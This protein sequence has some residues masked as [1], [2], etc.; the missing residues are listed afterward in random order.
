MTTKVPPGFG[1][2]LLER[3][4]DWAIWWLSVADYEA[5]GWLHS[6]ADIAL[7]KKDPNIN[8]AAKLRYDD[9]PW[10]DYVKDRYEEGHGRVGRGTLLIPPGC[11]ITV[12]KP[13]E[14]SPL[15]MATAKCFGIPVRASDAWKLAGWPGFLTW[16]DLLPWE[17]GAAPP[18]QAPA[19]SA[20]AEGPSGTGSGTGWTPET[21]ED[22]LNAAIVDA[23]SARIISRHVEKDLVEKLIEGAANIL[24]S[25]PNDGHCVIDATF[26]DVHAR[27]YGPLATEE[28]RKAMME[29]ARKEK[30]RKEA[31][32]R[33]R[34]EEEKKRH[35]QH[36][37]LTVNDLG[38]LLVSG[39]V[40]LLAALVAY[41]LVQ[42]YIDVLSP[43]VLIGAV[44]TLLGSAF[45]TVV[46][47][48]KRHHQRHHIHHRR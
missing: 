15:L 38:A 5:I 23:L 10:P 43:P 3:S 12:V 16:T 14:D 22:R 4:P 39:M 31:E 25:D 8:L 41:I 46:A 13:N 47:L 42:H 9:V 2:P 6:E 27:L 33:E 17:P 26:R 19:A 21:P 11:P 48:F 1:K 45:W 29:T 24:L 7:L 37:S 30:A 34:E 28:G 36:D 20:P 40:M 44:V 32:E 18:V 35:R